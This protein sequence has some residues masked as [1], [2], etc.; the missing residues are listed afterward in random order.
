MQ[1][2]IGE[3]HRLFGPALARR[4][5]DGVPAGVFRR[6]APRFRPTRLPRDPA[7]RDALRHRVADLLAT[8]VVEEVPRRLLRVACPLFVIRKPHAPSKF[9]LIH[10]LRYVNE[11]IAP[12]RFRLETA[13]TVRRVLRKGD[14]LSTTDIRSAYH[15]IPVRA[16]D[17]PL[18]GFSLEGRCYRYRALP[19]GLSSAPRLFSLVLRRVVAG[20]RAEGHRLV[21]YLDDVLA[22]GASRAECTVTTNMLRARLRSLGWTLAEE[23]L[24]S[25]SQRVE[26]LGLLWDAEQGSVSLPP[27][28]LAHLRRELRR[29]R[30]AQ[31][32]TL[33]Q[34]A[35]VTGLLNFAAGVVRP[36]RTYVHPFAQHVAAAWKRRQSWQAR[37]RV[38]P[39]LHELCDRWLR[40]LAEWNG[41]SSLPPAPV[42]VQISTDA[43]T[44]GWGATVDRAPAPLVRATANGG[45]LPHQRPL[46]ITWKELH[47]VTAGVREL[48]SHNGWRDRRILV[49]TDATTVVAY[50]RHQGGRRRRL[51][52][53][54]AAFFE[55]LWK[56][57]LTL[58]VRHLP[59]R[60]NDRADALSRPLTRYGEH[61]LRRSVFRA[62]LAWAGW[63]RVPVVDLFATASTARSPLYIAR[64]PDPRA[65]AT[66]ALTAQWPA[67]PLYAF[68]P[69]PLI[70]RTLELWEAL[71]HHRRQPMLLLVP[72]WPGRPWFPL[73]RRAGRRL[74]TLPPSVVVGC[75]RWPWALRAVLLS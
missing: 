28:K 50:L 8:G 44:H 27:R 13:A 32:V 68:P 62:L 35:G 48:A 70:P 61:V 43:S 26:F 42:T 4:L 52:D 45:F 17:R 73:L 47:A 38:H 65:V 41:V 63:A 11:H 39:R 36:G 60:L 30:R 40:C 21:Q 25:P 16:S 58:S 72:D 5:L 9:R 46:H 22:L 23:K 75:P 56:R 71:P 33:R 15:H 12:R 14:W 29:L 59:G 49:R 1:A 6:P 74:L 53:K 24:S 37:V 67:L 19:F 3:W 10:D 34:L 64:T 55:W 66:D 57:G 31:A 2:R 20:L 7:L 18:L 54:T 51:H 69:L